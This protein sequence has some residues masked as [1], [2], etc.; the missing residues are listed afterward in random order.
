MSLN[1]RLV[2]KKNKNELLNEALIFSH[3]HLRISLVYKIT[4]KKR[5]RV[6]HDVSRAVLTKAS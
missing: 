1:C 4:K 3:T 5:P 2:K 6:P